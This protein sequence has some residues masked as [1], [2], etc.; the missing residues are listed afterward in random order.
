MR[1]KTTEEFIE[2]SK[3]IYNDRYD[4]SSTDYVKNNIKVKILCK[5]HYLYFEQT[6]ANHLNF[7][8]CP[9]CYKNTSFLY[10]LILNSIPC[11]P[12]VKNILEKLPDVQ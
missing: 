2:Q 9:E 6:P 8:G 4:Y 1:R 3:K 7:E 5:T 10:P 12:I 11:P